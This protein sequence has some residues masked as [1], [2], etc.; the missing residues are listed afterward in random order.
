MNL[1]I[2]NKKLLL[3]FLFIMLS[4]SSLKSQVTQQWVK[5]YNHAYNTSS[6]GY[7]IKTDRFNNVFILGT[8]TNGPKLKPLICLI[9]FNSMGIT[10]WIARYDNGF[11]GDNFPW[12]MVIDSSGS[13]YI[14][15]ASQRDSL[16]FHQDIILLKYSTTGNLLMEKRYFSKQGIQ[17]AG[18]SLLLDSQQNIYIVG[19]IYILANGFMGTNYSLTI[20]CD[21]DGNMLWYDKYANGN[22]DCMTRY[23]GMDKNNNIYSG[24]YIFTDS[25]SNEY[26]FYVQKLNKDGEVKWRRSYFTE[27]GSCYPNVMQVSPSGNVYLGGAISYSNISFWDMGIIKYDSNGNLK[28]TKV[29]ENTS[30]RSDDYIFDMKLDNVEN[31]YFTGRD[32]IPG[33][34]LDIATGKVD[35]SSNLIWINHFDPFNGGED[36]GMS[37]DLDS[38]G[39]V[40]VTGKSGH[41]NGTDIITLRINNN[42]E[43]KWYKVFSSNSPA[44]EDYGESISI[45]NQNNILVGGY[46][47]TTPSTADMIAI[48]YSQTTSVNNENEL[49][50][51]RFELFQ[52]YPNPFNPKTNIEFKI[53]IPGEYE[54]KIFDISGKAIDTPLRKHLQSGKY[55]I[56]WNAE[57][58]PSGI[59]FYGLYK[60]GVKLEIKKMIYLK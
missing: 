49:S 11:N 47:Y 4:F 6:F 32:V 14:T 2:S 28:W 48:K 12:D 35:S 43:F 39:N 30:I 60:D 3:L 53:N 27:F 24:G 40:F 52:N 1:N 21:R 58:Y 50:D 45:D 41:K 37:I 55:I 54:L 33:N 16:I 29:I 22:I 8:S 59:Y 18:I 17:S 19:G 20:K 31:I 5:A 57:K 56:N 44:S 51:I 36:A 26:G 42:G 10:Q 7:K 38:F 15:G 25:M 23:I 46:S 34:Y 9:K 13:V